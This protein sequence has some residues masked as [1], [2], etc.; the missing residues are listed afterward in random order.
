MKKKKTGSSHHENIGT[1]ENRQVVLGCHWLRHV[2]DYTAK[3]QFYFLFVQSSEDSFFFPF[4]FF[5]TTSED[6]LNPEKKIASP[7]QFLPTFTFIIIK[8][9]LFYLFFIYQICHLHQTILH[10]YYLFYFL[11]SWIEIWQGNITQVLSAYAVGAKS[12][13]WDQ[14]C[15]KRFQ[16]SRFC[17]EL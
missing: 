12:G 7:C 13:A 9:Y 5:L 10:R 6:S 11:D 15:I 3:C 2:L 17:M 1:N 14:K 16:L 4:F 8:Y